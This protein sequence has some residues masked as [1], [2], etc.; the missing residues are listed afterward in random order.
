MVGIA[1]G[2]LICLFGRPLLSIYI[3][4]SPEAIEYGMVRFACL[5]IPYFICGLMDVTTGAIRG[6]GTS[7]V[8]MII[9]ILGACGLRILWVYTIFQIPQYHTPTG[10]YLSYPASWVVTFIAQLAAFFI[11]YK[12]LS[13]QHHN[14]H[15]LG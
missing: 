6:L 13:K 11:V 12:R 10:L 15:T 5:C 8:P 7:F 3:S 4:D 2:A 14:A 9:T 1:L